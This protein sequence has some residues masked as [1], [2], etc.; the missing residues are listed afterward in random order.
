MAEVITVSALN[1]YVKT[2]LDVNDALFDLALRGSEVAKYRTFEVY[3]TQEYE[4]CAR[5]TAH[6]IKLDNRDCTGL[7]FL[8]LPG[9]IFTVSDV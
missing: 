6:E 8:A 7:C 3:R 4:D 1:R 5:V 2:L 9:S